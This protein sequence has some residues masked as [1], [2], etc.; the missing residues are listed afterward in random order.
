[1]PE[2]ARFTEQAREAMVLAQEEAARLGHPWLGTEH[3]LLGLLRQQDARARRV[4]S[5][6]GVSAASVARELVEELGEPSET[7][8]LGEEDE[9]ALRTLGID[10][11]EVRRRV[12]DVF[13][14]GALERARPGRCGLPVMP[15]LKQSLERAARVAKGGSIDTD[16]L[17]L[18]MV[19]V[20][21]AL[22]A[23]LMRRLGVTAD[24]VWVAVEAQRR[25]AS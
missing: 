2:F 14:P 8:P 18:G 21:D 24:A 11:R 6:L 7:R 22:A 3:L 23:G 15:R 20:P 17:L 13:G 19:Q 10:L 16:H 5:D 1:M 9:V 4:L 12:E 25:Q